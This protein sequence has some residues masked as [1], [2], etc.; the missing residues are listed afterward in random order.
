M[1]SLTATSSSALTPT[2][3]PIVLS[4]DIPSPDDAPIERGCGKRVERPSILLRDFVTPAHPS[5][6]PSQV[7]GLI[8]SAQVLLTP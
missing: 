8:S 2:A 6:S 1:S 4:N 3:T 7:H 5:S